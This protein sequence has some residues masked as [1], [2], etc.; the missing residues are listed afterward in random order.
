MKSLLW[1]NPYL[2]RYR[3]EL[4][5]GL[6][7]IL[8]TNFF[9]MSAPKFVGRAID[10]MRSEFYAGEVGQNILLALLCSLLSGFFMFLVRQFIIVASR[11]IEFD[12][13]NDFYAH[14]QTLS[15]NFFRQHSTGDLMS[16]ATNDLNAV[17]NYL[18]PGIMY[19]LNTAFRLVF[20]LSAMLTVSPVLTLFALLPAPLLSYLV[21]RMGKAIH[22]Q[23]QVLQQQYGELTT[24]V[25]ENLAGIRVV[26]AFVREDSEQQAFA[27]L[28][29]A[30]FTQNLKLAR[31]Q[32]LFYPI[33]SSLLGL[34]V[35]LVIWVGGTEVT[36]GTVTLG[37]MTQF[38]MYIVT[39]GWPLIS[40]GWVTNI[41]Q[42][43]AA[44]QARINAVM[45]TQPDIADSA[46]TD[47]RITHLEGDIEFRNVSFAYPSSPER[48][49][50]RHLSFSIP[51][52][53]K[54][55]IVG[56]TGSGKTTLVS[57][58]ARLYEPTEGEIFIDGKPLRTIPLSVLRKAIGF[59]P[60]DHFLFSDTIRHNLAFGAPDASEA[61]IH[62][63]AW[64][65][66]LEEDIAHFPAGY[67]TLVGE[68]GITLSGGQKQRAAI[69]RALLR[70]P[71]ILVL[72]DALSAVDTYTEDTILRRLQTAAAS[73]TLILISHRISTVKNADM[74]IVL[75][76]GKIV[77]CGTH[78]ELLAQ[79]GIYAALYRKQ[80]LEE[81]ISQ[82]D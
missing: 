3:R 6:L 78:A 36:K 77:E 28:S 53:S 35:M 80:L 25:Q 66:A 47:L 10:A 70:Q 81:E 21:Y 16:R 5:A 24:K 23:S 14:L 73:M 39:L 20:A 58:L 50:L 30:Y 68:R 67:D 49:V 63:A 18:G 13:K 26:K 43:A 44:A 75:D 8:L 69:A 41:V 40:I 37:Q 57:L 82:L 31:L 64:V 60:Q 17:R 12:L 19:S 62:S 65:A 2:W 27:A 11:K 22:N 56:A 38:L 15:Q 7:C 29:M 61:Q 4:A 79:D 1:L 46:D 74:I 34:S 9:M 59:V 55:A 72:D 48:W 45:T 52:G 71:K 76:E 54:F 42:R 33:M 32:A 51:R